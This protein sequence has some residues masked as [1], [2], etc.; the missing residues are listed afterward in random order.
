MEPIEIGHLIHSVSAAIRAAVSQADEAHGP[1]LL[2]GFGLCTDN[3]VRT[4]YHVYATKDW[5]SER[6]ASYPEI[7]MTAVE[8]LQ[9]S[10]ESDF[11]AIS[12]QLADWA[13]SDEQTGSIHPDRGPMI[14]F[15]VLFQALKICRDEGLF[16]PDTFLCVGSTDPDPLM[17]DLTC[18]AAP[19]LN[20]P[21]VASAYCAMMKGQS[22]R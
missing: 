18:A 3:D 12:L 9:Q 15:R 19:L 20:V 16:A 11:D 8:W 4:L 10:D 21:E 1:D 22:A 14:R 6:A 7:G 13:R 2:H 5:L 17:V